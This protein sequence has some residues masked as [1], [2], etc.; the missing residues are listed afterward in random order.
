MILWIGIRTIR[1]RFHQDAATREAVRAGM[2][3]LI[4]SCLFGVFMLINCSRQ[5]TIG[6]QLGIGGRG[7]VPIQ[8]TV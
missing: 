7:G 8:F 4:L 5:M 6:R 2:V 1:Q 3:F